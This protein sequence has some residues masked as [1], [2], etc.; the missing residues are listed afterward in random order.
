[1]DWENEFSHFWL[2]RPGPTGKLKGSERVAKYDFN[3]Q[4]SI[5]AAAANHPGP[6]LVQYIKEGGGIGPWRPIEAQSEELPPLSLSAAPPR[7]AGFIPAQE[8]A[9]LML[10]RMEIQ[11]LKSDQ[12]RAVDV[13]WLQNEVSN[14]RMENTRL[15]MEAVEKQREAYRQGR[16][17]MRA[18]L[19]DLPITEGIGVK[20]ILPFLS[21]I[22]S[23]PAPPQAAPQAA[24]HAP[25]QAA[26]QAAPQAQP[27]AA[28][29]TEKIIREMFLNLI[30]GNVTADEFP[31]YAR[32]TVGIDGWAE[33]M[34]NKKLIVDAIMN[35]PSIKKLENGAYENLLEAF[36]EKARDMGVLSV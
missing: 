16:E 31:A 8:S 7:A 10:M 5:E 24:P 1:M 11:S 32:R 27:Q 33:I 14:L 22:A 12:S 2:R 20:E 25:P 18:E 15:L 13:S 4:E 21:G 26:P 3:G 9:E 30:D 19:D 6:L 23:R 36:D 28:P 29:D 17:D 34:E 35:D